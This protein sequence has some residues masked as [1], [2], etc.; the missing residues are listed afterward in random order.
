[1]KILIADDEEFVRHGICVLLSTHKNMQVCGEA[2]NG[3]DAI[4][5]AE[6]LA[7]DVIIMDVSMPVINGFDA[8]REIR[9][10]LP[11]CHILLLTQYDV[12]G[13]E[14]EGKRIGA[15]AFISKASI[16]T[17]LL[18]ALRAFLPRMHKTACDDKSKEGS[19]LMNPPSCFAERAQ[20]ELTGGSPVPAAGMPLIRVLIA[21]DHDVVRAGARFILSAGDVKVYEASNGIEAVRKALEFKP[22]LVILD[23]TMPVMGGYAAAKELHRVVPNIPVLFFSMHHTPKLVEDAKKVGARG[24]VHK[25]NATKALLDAVNQLVVHKGTYFPVPMGSKVP[26]EL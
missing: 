3:K 7:P 11:Q 21:D 6:R 16:W 24:F 23:L 20:R 1:L 22:D 4:A 12:P 10:F 5:K 17:G 19:I 14:V 9:R 18:P 25:A 26:T 15:D 13:I 2:L 8:T